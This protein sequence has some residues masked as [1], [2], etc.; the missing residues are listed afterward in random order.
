MWPP[1]KGLYLDEN[2]N[3]HHPQGKTIRLYTVGEYISGSPNILNNYV[4]ILFLFF[5]ILQMRKWAT[6]IA[7]TIVGRE[8]TIREA[9]Q[10]ISH[11]PITKNRQNKKS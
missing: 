7:V 11:E 8:I 10:K 2:F 9:L 1:P 5:S 4:A 3:T 6:T